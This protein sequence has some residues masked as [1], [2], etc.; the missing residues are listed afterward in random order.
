[1]FLDAWTSEGEEN[2]EGGGGAT[3]A[4]GALLVRGATE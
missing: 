1:M 2:V 3:F 4:V